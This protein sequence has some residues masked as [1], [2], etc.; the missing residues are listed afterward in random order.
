MFAGDALCNVQMY[1]YSKT[2][3]FTIYCGSRII[4]L[5]VK[6]I[7]PICDHKT[8]MQ[9]YHNSRYKIICGFTAA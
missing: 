5:R 2:M 3:Y 7:E 1:L 9:K 8:Y 4:Y 6:E